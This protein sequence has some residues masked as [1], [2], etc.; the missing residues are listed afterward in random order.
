[1]SVNNE[2]ELIQKITDAI[3]PT[4]IAL[5]HDIVLQKSLVIPVDKDITLKSDKAE[6]FYKLIGAIQTD[7]V[8]VEG[9]LSLD[10]V[11]VTHAVGAN[12]CGVRV[13][14]GGALFLCS[15]EISDN[16]NIDYNAYG[17]GVYV[18]AGGSFVMSGGVISG[19]S[20]YYNGGGIFS[21][22]TFEMSGGMITKNDANSAGGGVSN[23][24][25][26]IMVGG[27]VSDNTAA[28]G[29]GVYN[30]YGGV[31]EMS[32]G[33]ISGNV[34]DIDGGGVYLGGGC[35][36]LSGGSKVFG[37]VAGGNGGGVGGSSR[38]LSGL[39]VRSGVEFSN[40]RA[41]KA[42]DRLP[43]QDDIY[44]E[45]IDDNVVW[46]V[47]F[48]QGYNNYDIGNPNGVSV[49]FGVVVNGSCVGEGS[50][51][52]RYSE[53][54]TVYIDAGARNGY[55]FIGWTIV[56]GGVVLLSNVGKTCF[57][58]PACSV[59]VTAEWEAQKFDVVVCDSFALKSG[60]G[61]YSTGVVVT[62]DA[63]VRE[64]YSFVGW[65]VKGGVVVVDSS[66]SVC[67]VMPACDVEVVAL[68]RADEFEVVVDGDG[69]L[70][71]FGAGMYQHGETVFIRAGVRVG[72]VFVGWSVINGKVV[73]KDDKVDTCFVMP[74]EDVKLLVNWKRA[75]FNVKVISEAV[76]DAEGSGGYSYGD[77]VT[78]NAGSRKGYIFVGWVIK[79]NVIT[80][81][82]EVSVSFVM[83]ACD[84]EVVALWELAQFN[85]IIKSENATSVSGNGLCSFDE[86]V[87]I[88]AGVRDG[89]TFSS[90]S[91]D[92][93]DG[94]I[95]LKNVS[96]TTFK[97]PACSV[98]LT[99][100]WVQNRYDVKINA[101][102]AVDVL[103][104]GSYVQGEVVKVVAGVCSGYVFVGW[105]V[106][107]DV[108][109]LSGGAVASFVM[110]ACS[111]V[112]TANW[113][114]DKYR[115]TVR[116]SYAQPV[117]A[118][119]V[120]DYLSGV[121][122]KV[123]AGIRP[124]YTFDYWS[125]ENNITLPNASKASFVM[126]AK[127][128]TIV[129][130][131][132]RAEYNVT[133]V[134]ENATGAIGSGKYVSGQTVKANAG[135]RKGYT[136]I[137]WTVKNN[138]VTMPT[139]V[140][141]SFIMP[142][143]DVVLTAFWKQDVYSV[144]I[145]GG[146]AVNMVGSGS[147]AQGVTVQI[148]AGVRSGYSFVGWTVN[149]G[150][151]TL[152]NSVSASFIMPAKPVTL[153]AKWKNNEHVVTNIGIFT[154]P[155]ISGSNYTSFPSGGYNHVVLNTFADRANSEQ[156]FMH[157]KDKILD[158][159]KH[160]KGDY[161]NVFY[162]TVQMTSSSYIGTAVSDIIVLNGKNASAPAGYMKIDVDLNKT[163]GGDF[164]YLAY[165]KV[166]ASDT[167]VINF[168]GGV[169]YAAASLENLPSNDNGRWT[170]VNQCSVTGDVQQVADLNKGCGQK[171]QY[172]RLIVHKIPR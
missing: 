163:A 30:E 40:N 18:S 136:F 8:V 161:I 71:L 160:A 9:K 7:T 50:G 113:K 68:W 170:W 63:G 127:S 152:P 131:W 51:V 168:I 5:T 41:R 84:V 86:D 34:V 94:S 47:P 101:G 13:S 20:A 65:F 114:L 26:F 144:K 153:T 57:V 105:S 155:L 56:K 141:A 36:V 156:D 138:V 28:A 102:G 128:V 21:E 89:Y 108:V 53:N 132:K 140:A 25:E 60:V 16:L 73:L 44:D 6:G 58:M 66:V 124:D 64:N 81:P 158:C 97:M 164:L 48:D 162:T 55:K 100:N 37:N 167:E 126:P 148:S 147:Y 17:G 172:I 49:R 14:S 145:G 99:A 96:P 85:V 119:G 46:S 120:G 139:S 77:N 38:F 79:G 110:P 74:A 111:V 169:I 15:G 116:D 52:G 35:V 91:I 69:G 93:S 32:G 12:G 171:S 157:K 165:K 115:V 98:V 33:V 143:C 59:E 2:S 62:I 19:N 70:S 61:V 72:Y 149:E 11:V 82:N 103:G 129:A 117:E 118:S 121:T 42:F 151:I 4:T 1:M 123:D 76:E 24:G 75:D 134:S 107:G 22:G 104:G 146:G 67:F 130:N 135:A 166:T 154:R 31:F 125:N 106:K 87:I 92:K 83:P 43:D 10:G 150:N 80:L 54:T 3:E 78:I 88:D 112:L 27:I 39:W 159:N 109:V 45:H 95:V 122:V 90:W 23:Y 142:M 137:S 29:G 133:V